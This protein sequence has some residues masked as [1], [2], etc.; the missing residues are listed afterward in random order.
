MLVTHDPF[1]TFMVDGGSLY[2][3]HSTGARYREYPGGPA[4]APTSPTKLRR[5]Q[6]MEVSSRQQAWD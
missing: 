5:E 4:Q 3:A 6:P 2:Q 1:R